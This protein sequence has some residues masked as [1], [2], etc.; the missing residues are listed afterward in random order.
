MN[1]LKSCMATESIPRLNHFPIHN[2]P[3]KQSFGGR[4]MRRSAASL[5]KQAWEILLPAAEA[6]VCVSLVTN[7][8]NKLP[9]NRK[10]YNIFLWIC[11]TFILLRHTFKATFVVE[12]VNFWDWKIRPEISS[13]LVKHVAVVW[14]TNT[15]AKFIRHISSQGHNYTRWMK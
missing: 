3:C 5:G 11:F 9:Q 1:S 13:F 7:H 4:H 2:S 14:R 15:I 6:R 12:H 10:D 8:S